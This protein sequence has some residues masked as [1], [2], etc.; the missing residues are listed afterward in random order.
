MSHL[1]IKN[2][3]RNQRTQQPDTPLPGVEEVG[4][5][6]IQ[7][8]HQDTYEVSG[9]VRITRDVDWQRTGAAVEKLNEPTVKKR[10]EPAVK[11]V[12]ILAVVAGLAQ[13][14]SITVAGSLLPTAPMIAIGTVI[15]LLVGVSAVDLYT[16][17]NF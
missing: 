14:A 13:F 17:L 16:N 8:G 2:E 6:V 5:A 9:K 7:Q 1:Q 4:E 12:S 3:V 11:L 15:A 10:I